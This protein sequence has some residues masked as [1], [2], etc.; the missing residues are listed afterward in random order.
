[1]E[2]ELNDCKKCVELELEI[3]KKNSEFELLEGKFGALAVEKIAIDEELGVLKKKYDE[4][5]KKMTCAENGNKVVTTGENGREREVDVTD[6]KDEGEKVFNL[7]IEN[8]VLDCEKKKAES[9]V[10]FWKAKFK[11]LEAREL[12][13]EGRD[14]EH[15]LA[16]K[17]NREPILSEM[18]ME[19]MSK[20]SGLKNQSSIANRSA[21]LQAPKK[22]ADS[23]ET[24]QAAVGVITTRHHSVQGIGDLQASVDRP[25]T[26]APCKHST[27]IEGGVRGSLSRTELEHGSQVR[28]QL[29]FGE[30]S[31]SKKMAPP[32]PGGLRRASVGVIDIS[33]SDGEPDST[34]HHMSTLENQENKTVFVSTDS[35][36]GGSRNIKG[37]NSETENTIKKDFL[38]QS[39]EEEMGGYKGGSAFISTPKRKRTSNI[40]TSDTEN[41]D[42]D[43]VPICKLKTDFLPM[44]HMDFQPNSAPLPATVSGG[45][46]QESASRRR[47]VSLRNLVS[48]PKRKRASDI[49]TSDSESEHDDNVPICMLK[50]NYLPESN[51][52]FQLNICSVPATVSRDKVLESVTRRRLGSLKKF[53]ENL[54]Q[55]RSPTLNTL[56]IDCNSRISTKD[57][58]E[59][60]DMEENRSESEGESLGGFIVDGSDVSENSESTDDLRNSDSVDTSGES[61]N[62]SDVKINYGKIMSKLRR[63]RDR[64][65]K[66]EF[67]A[68][69]LADFGKDPELCMKAVCVL[70]RQQT[71]EEKCCKGTIYSNQRGFSQCDA[72]RG[73]SLAE[74]LT[75]GNPGGD[76]QKSVKELK[77]YDRKGIEL[78]RKL[79][80]HYSKQLFAIYQSKE[81][82][83]FLPS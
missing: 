8:K 15:L 74:F 11:V 25:S 43:N 42:D 81:D 12:E 78:C 48:T 47:L 55:K 59:D 77:E 62:T 44:L 75:D 83:F 57:D 63:N 40:V 2:R 46:V 38:D 31:P 36:A 50:T 82:P 5:K 6:E 14:G 69:M 54:L 32:T 64:N 60:A 70:Y 45:K 21:H 35:V 1:M 61:E 30:G 71:S 80:T 7:V 9:E 20:V 39:D 65:L 52:D 67:E 56:E 16:G 27:H 22:V 29:A 33:D 51:T 49:V 19:V 34:M 37:S 28:K 23:K 13:F 73:T 4:L 41:E 53:E 24:V 79:A 66:W 72:H 58:G 17:L 10:E 26:G 76:L 18:G 68:D 3:Q